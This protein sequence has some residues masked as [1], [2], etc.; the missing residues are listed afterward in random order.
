MLVVEG[1][2][3]Y[4]GCKRRSFHYWSIMTTPTAYGLLCRVPFSHP[5]QQFCV[6][7]Y[8]FWAF[9]P[10]CLLMR[11]RV[12]D[13]LW[14][15]SSAVTHCIWHL[16]ISMLYSKSMWP[17]PSRKAADSEHRLQYLSICLF[18]G[19]REDCIHDSCRGLEYHKSWV[20][21]KQCRFLFRWQQ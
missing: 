10:L 3:T 15:I 21:V 4:N 7:V 8:V 5:E 12:W 16:W 2:F 1:G 14:W 18:L 17:I 13:N 6:Y 9:L 19:R 11:R 20:H